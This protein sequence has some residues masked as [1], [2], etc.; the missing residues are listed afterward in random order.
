ME[1]R[2]IGLGVGAGFLAGLASFRYA[3][4]QAAPLIAGAIEYEEARSHAESS[5][6]GG[7]SHEHEVFTRSV[8][9]NFGAGV[10]TVGFAVISGALFA[11]AFAIAVAVLRR[12]R[13]DADPRCVAALLACGAFITVRVVP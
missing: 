7:Y 5:L 1:K 11:V 12:H 13:V 10:G 4:L 3:R 8:Q 2:I 9:E 6:S